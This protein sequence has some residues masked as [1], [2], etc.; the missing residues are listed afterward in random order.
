MER[1]IYKNNFLK[2]DEI[3]HIVKEQLSLFNEKIKKTTTKTIYGKLCELLRSDLGFH[4]QQSSYSSHN[5]HSFPAKFPPQLPKLFIEALTREGDVVLDPMVGSGTTII[6]AYLANRKSI[7]FDIDPLAIKLSRVKSMPLDKKEL[8]RLGSRIYSDAK[9]EYYDNKDELRQ[10]LN[11]KFDSKTQEFLNY[12]FLKETQLELLSI[13][14]QIEKIESE[15]FRNFFEIVFSSVIITK[16]GGVSLALDLGHTRPHKLKALLDNNGNIIYGD[17]FVDIS[18]KSHLTKIIKSPIE[19]FRRRI[20]QNIKSVISNSKSNTLPII[21]YGDSQKLNLVNDT[22]DF[23]ITSPPYAS[24]AI[25]YMRAHKFSLIWLGFK[26]EDLTKKRNEYIG[27]ESTINYQFE[28]L[29]DY[30][31]KKVNE[32]SNVNINRG[33]VLKRY[34]T[35]MKKSLREMHRV[36]KPGKSAIVVVGSSMM[37]GIDTETHICLAEIGS[38]IGFTDPFIGIRELDRNKRMLPAGKQ[39]NILSP[40][41]Q[42]MHKEYVIGFYKP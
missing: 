10:A 21:N 1:I 30:T 4:N 24:N 31:N 42:R 7:G 29:P 11:D 17:K 40:I 25:D 16:S 20:N 41:Q 28:D 15:D 6:E 34:F 12:W 37:K 23:I 32:V 9:I 26:I 36:L 18:K 3:G 19:E 14:R 35:E 13:K 39:I 5:F 33:K 22:I 27:S 2:E 8:I 38:S